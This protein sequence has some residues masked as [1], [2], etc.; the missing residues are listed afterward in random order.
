MRTP[1]L[2]VVAARYA[3]G[4]IPSWELPAVADALLDR[5]CDSR[6]AIELAI[7]R[8]PTMAD[9]GPLLE[10][11]L[12]E[13]G[14]SRPSVEDAVLT[15]LRCELDRI[16]RRVVKPREGLERVMKLVDSQDFHGKARVYVG[17]SH[18]LE[19]LVG[20]YWS[21][22]DLDEMSRGGMLEGHDEA[23]KELDEDVVRRAQEWMEVYG[24]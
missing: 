7:L 15:V 1:D 22:D 16:A 3:L 12:E 14:V 8:Y 24:T 6:A 9:A 23:R 13:E 5:G 19:R 20:A 11:V 2:T 18:G 10:R 17:D 21:Y 4:I